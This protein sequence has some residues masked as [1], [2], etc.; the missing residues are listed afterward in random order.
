MIKPKL[1]WMVV[2]KLES[3]STIIIPETGKT[4]A[5]LTPYQILSIGPGQY[6]HGVFVK[7]LQEPGDTV[8]INGP[9]AETEYDKIKYNFAREAYIVA[10]LT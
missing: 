10:E 9:I 3:K 4:V 1:D 7:T 8:F 6:V 2:R 5:E